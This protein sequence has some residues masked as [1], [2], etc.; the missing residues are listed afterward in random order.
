MAA[1]RIDQAPEILSE[2]YSRRAF[3]L[4]STV[5]LLIAVS[6]S[7]LFALTD[8]ISAESAPVYAIFAWYLLFCGAVF[9]L[10][11]MRPALGSGWSIA[12]HANDL[13]AFAA[14]MILT[15]GP[16]S[17]FFLFLILAVL[18]ATIQ[19]GWSGAVLTAAAVILI[20]SGAVLLVD[21]TPPDL[22][23]IVLRAVYLGATAGLLVYL[24]LRLQRLH[25]DLR[26]LAFPAQREGFAEPEDAVR[27]ASR[28]FGRSEILLV[29]QEGARAV[30]I[31]CCR[32]ALRK[33]S[34]PR[35]EIVHPE[36]ESL[37]FVAKDWAGRASDCTAFYWERGR[38]R[39]WRGR[40]I[41]H[42]VDGPPGDA[43]C[44]RIRAM[45]RTGRLL[46]LGLEDTTTDDLAIATVLGTEIALLLDRRDMLIQAGRAAALEER[47][48]LARELHDGI[49]QVLTSL[50]LQIE[51]AIRD[52]ADSS[53]STAA[54]LRKLQCNIE[55]EQA[56]FRTYI[57]QLRDM[58]AYL[59]LPAEA[60]LHTVFGDLA[61]RLS[62]RW[63]LE[64]TATVGSGAEILS[65]GIA[66][67]L[68]WLISEAAANAAKHG[69]A[70]RFR[71]TLEGD[72]SSLLLR[73]SDDGR[74][75]FELPSLRELKSKWL[76]PRSLRDRVEG[77]GGTLS[78]RSDQGGTELV[79]TLPQSGDA[80]EHDDEPGAG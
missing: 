19:W 52:S 30:E 66:Q 71:W 60:S 18:G 78:I 49:L 53:P 2:L 57:Q 28:I 24:A 48:R 55:T 64:V 34:V 16:L 63:G 61:H 29:L 73:I 59:A 3:K 47:M 22:R 51:K 41:A 5:R 21:P 10:S 27:Q 6:T 12:S 42:E 46:I 79:I 75:G 7:L 15:E 8:R 39:H 44:V 74:G 38:L 68:V 40:P 36:L 13:I 72:G 65:P 62:R 17:P 33:R 69:N 25:R 43:I 70:T 67:Q 1:A 4:L 50:S 35:H 26:R 54:S 76:G 77:M 31:R 45:T 37:D 23:R 20:Y 11:R 32:G 56:E 80:A 9:A 14:L 58:D